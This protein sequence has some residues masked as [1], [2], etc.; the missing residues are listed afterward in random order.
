MKRIMQKSLGIAILAAFVIMA[1]S[2]CFDSVDISYIILLLAMAG[3]F[4]ASL[5]VFYIIYKARGGGKYGRTAEN[6][7][8]KHEE[9]CDPDIPGHTKENR[10]AASLRNGA[11]GIPIYLFS[12]YMDHESFSVVS[13][14]AY[15][16]AMFVFAY[17]FFS[18]GKT[19]KN[20]HN[21]KKSAGPGI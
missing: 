2:V 10:M 5:G 8:D 1:V 11:Y 16:L 4:V 17:G 12:A 14:I 19:N 13:L 3:V 21:H 6:K 15:V 7:S 9:I 18:I 20:R